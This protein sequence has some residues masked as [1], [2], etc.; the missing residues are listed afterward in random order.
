LPDSAI[1]LISGHSSKKRLEVYQHLSSADVQAG[2]QKATRMLN[3]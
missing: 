3:I 2:Y 1:Q